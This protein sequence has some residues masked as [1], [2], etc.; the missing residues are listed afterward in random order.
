M[1]G[2]EVARAIKASR[3]SLRV[4]L[5]TGWGEEPPGFSESGFIVDFVLPKPLTREALRQAL[6][7]A[8]ILIAP[9]LS[10]PGRTCS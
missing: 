10:G 4:G 1:T 6:A 7:P 5:C 8:R 2:W 9:G 3:P